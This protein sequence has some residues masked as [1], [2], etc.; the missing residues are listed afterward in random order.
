MNVI[1]LL[2]E[3]GGVGKTAA[4]NHL[5]WGL[6]CRGRRVLLIDGDP[7]GHATIRCG[8]PKA[9]GLYDLL[10]RDADWKTAAKVVAPE[11]YGLP[12]ERV[13]QG[14]LYVLPGN[15][16]T[17]SIGSNIDDFDKLAGRLDE[18]K[19]LVD[20]VVIDTSP[21][22]SLLHG[23][24]YNAS[25]AILYPTQLEFGSFDGLVES[26]RHRQAADT[27]RQTRWCRPAIEVLGI[28][29]TFYRGNT[30]EQRDNLKSLQGEFGSLVWPEIP[31]ATVWTE[32]ASRA[33]P[34]YNMQPSSAAAKHVWEM[35]ERVERAYHVKQAV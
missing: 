25:D 4:G 35:V 1:T 33:L 20:F 14:K 34:V 8:L 28:L 19:P 26:I 7:Q 15:V 11:R 17:R 22:P 2:N 5:A 9:P 23:L 16:E 24:F 12:G 21:T 18:V 6:A 32:Y 10:V 30:G 3:K 13:P 27:A 31:L 29:P